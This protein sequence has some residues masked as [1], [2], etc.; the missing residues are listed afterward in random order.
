MPVVCCAQVSEGERGGLLGAGW[1]RAKELSALQDQ[2]MAV[3]YSLADAAGG[4]GRDAR[5][6]KGCKLLVKVRGFARRGGT[7]GRG[8]GERREPLGGAAFSCA[9]R[10]C[11]RS[12]T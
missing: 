1:P 7:C 5:R 4:A 12:A 6:V 2:C 11:S 9:R 10:C 8:P 3:L